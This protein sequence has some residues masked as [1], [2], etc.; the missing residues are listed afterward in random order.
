MIS[1]LRSLPRVELG[2]LPGV[3]RPSTVNTTT[4]A[5]KLGGVT[6]WLYINSSARRKCFNEFSKAAL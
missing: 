1:I 3:V 6:L 5:E 2:R 4:R